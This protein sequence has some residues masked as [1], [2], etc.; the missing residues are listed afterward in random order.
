MFDFA[1]GFFRRDQPFCVR[2]FPQVSFVAD[3]EPHTH[4][5][6]R[7]SHAGLSCCRSGDP[8]LMH[9]S[10][11]FMRKDQQLHAQIH[12]CASSLVISLATC[13]QQSAASPCC[14][15]FHRPMTSLL[16]N[17][18]GKYNL[19]RLFGCVALRLHLAHAAAD[20]RIYCTASAL[21]HTSLSANSQRL[22]PSNI[23]NVHDLDEC[24]ASMR[25]NCSKRNAAAIVAGVLCSD[26]P[27]CMPSSAIWA[28]R[29]RH[30]SSI[31]LP[32][33]R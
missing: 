32:A 2:E 29:L 16:V 15:F 31:I 26:H 20:N 14:S 17:F 23:A 27:S 13:S 1:Q 9:S 22:I 8:S 5:T 6:F 3:S 24:C 19:P 21:C 30:A 12:R 33:C 10:I 11:P 25:S 4:K 18:S 28:G 7:Q